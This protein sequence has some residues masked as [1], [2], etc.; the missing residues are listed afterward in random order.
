MLVLVRRDWPLPVPEQRHRQRA[1]PRLALRQQVPAQAQGPARPEPGVRPAAARLWL[2][3]V[4]VERRPAPGPWRPA[5]ANARTRTARLERRLVPLWAPLPFRACLR[6]SAQAYRRD[7]KHRGRGLRPVVAPERAGLWLLWPMP[8]ALRPVRR[9]PRRTELR[10]QPRP[11][12]APVLQRAFPEHRSSCAGACR[13]GSIQGS[14][15]GPATEPTASTSR[16]SIGLP[17]SRRI[18]MRL[19]ERPS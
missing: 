10:P 17:H 1:Q 8:R 12:R 18:T 13:R 6:P 11:V 7:G 19:A 5:I 9:E 14:K 3:Q 16:S 4:L 15:Q 2:Q